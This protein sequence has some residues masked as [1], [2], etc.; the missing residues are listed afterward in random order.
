MTKQRNGAGW[1][2]FADG[3][4]LRRQHRH[5]SDPYVIPH[6][7]SYLVGPIAGANDDGGAHGGTAVRVN[8]EA[9]EPAK[10]AQSRVTSSFYIR[11]HSSTHP[12]TANG[13]RRWYGHGDGARR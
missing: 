13:G 11:R 12:I 1:P 6:L 5:Y 9:P 4:L 10:A 8:G 3:E 7:L 2:E